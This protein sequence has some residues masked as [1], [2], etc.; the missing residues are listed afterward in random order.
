MKNYLGTLGLAQRA[1]KLAFGEIALNKV[2]S[3]EAHL[4]IL[5]SDVGENTKNKF[6]NKCHYYDIEVVFMDSEDIAI[7]LGKSNIKSI[8]VLDKGFASKLTTCLKG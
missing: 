6:I 8:A 2:S 1:R 4:V 7:A 3:Q 5:S